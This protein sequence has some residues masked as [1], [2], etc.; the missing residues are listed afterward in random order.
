MI[1]RKHIKYKDNKFIFDDRINHCP[2]DHESFNI[3][4]WYYPATMSHTE[5]VKHFHLRRTKH[6]KELMLQLSE[7]YQSFNDDY[8]SYMLGDLP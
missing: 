1:E 2:T 7:D 8:L 6:Y 4:E 3:D 5:A